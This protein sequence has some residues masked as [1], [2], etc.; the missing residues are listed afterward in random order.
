GAAVAMPQGGADRLGLGDLGGQ[1]RRS[2]HAGQ[3]L[4]E[5]T[6]VHDR[7]RD[8]EAELVGVLLRA[9]YDVLR[10]LEGQWHGRQCTSSLAA[11]LLRGAVAIVTGGGTGIGRAVSE[12][13]AR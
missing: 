1:R 10:L 8:A 4:Q 5:A 6:L 9:V 7:H 12:S 11:M 2:V 13:L 3:G